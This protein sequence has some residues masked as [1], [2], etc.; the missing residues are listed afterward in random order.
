MIG[1]NCT[2]SVYPITSGS[3][4]TTYTYAV[5]P[6]LSGIEAYIEN[7]KAEVLMALGIAPNIEEYIM[8]CDPIAIAIGDKVVCSGGNTYIVQAIE[9]H[10]GNL[11][12]EDLYTVTLHKQIQ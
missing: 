2:I 1:S 9:R 6:S 7:Q 11:D 3:I 5:S 10:E 8:Q 4:A 12:V